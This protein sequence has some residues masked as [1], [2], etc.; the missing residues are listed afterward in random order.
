M[1]FRGL[2]L[3]RGPNIWSRVTA[4]EVT[5]DLDSLA[6]HEGPGGPEL[7]RRLVS[8]LPGLDAELPRLDPDTEAS[9][10]GAYIPG[11]LAEVVLEL[12][13]RAGCAV[14]FRRLAPLPDSRLVRV[15]VQYEAEELARATLVVARSL[16]LSAMSD[17]PFALDREQA[18]LRELAEDVCLGPSTRAIVNAALER[19][20]PIHR[21]NSGSLVQLGHGA[22]QHRIFTAETDQ[23]SAIAECIAQDKDLTRRLLRA[24]GVRVPAGRPVDGPEDA[25]EA[26][27][28]IGAPVV[29]KPRYGNHGRGVAINLTSRQQVEAAYENAR[30]ER[31]GVMVE[32]FISGVEHRLLVVGE[33]LV[34]AARGEPVWVV[35]DGARHV[36]A[37]IDALNQD[38]RRG[39]ALAL[40][41]SRI[42]FDPLTRLLLEQQGYRPD[43]V[44]PAGD[45]VLVRRNGDLTIDATDDVHP[46]VARQAVLAA[47]VVGLNVAGLDIVAT[48]ISRPLEEQGGA[49]VEVNAGPG[50]LMHLLPSKGRPRPVGEAIIETMYPKGSD[51][52]V[53]IIAVTGTNGKT[54]TARIVARGLEA[55]GITVGLACSDGI[56]VQQA[57][58]DTGDCSGPRSARAVLLH[59]HVEAAVLETGRGGL[60]REGLGFDE[61]AVGIV[62]NIGGGDHLGEGGIESPRDLAWVK[63]AVVDA[64]SPRGA[65]VLNA[66]DALAV[67][68]ATRCRGK[69]ILFASA[70]ELAPLV[71][72]RANGGTALFLEEGWITLATN[73]ATE[74]L[75]H[76]DAI[77]LVAP[78]P[79]FMIENILAAVA[80]LWQVGI[81][82]SALR[83]GL[84]SFAGSFEQLPGRWQVRAFKEATVVVDECHNLSAL[85][86]AIEGLERF[87][88]RRRAI[89][90][91][92]RGG[93]DQ[94]L[95][96]QGQLL[97]TYFDRVV[98]FDHGAGCGR[99]A[100]DAAQLLRAGAKSATR[101]QTVSYCPA[102]EDAV[103]TVLST[104]QADELVLIQNDKIDKTRYL[105]ESYGVGRQDAS[106]IGMTP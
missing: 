105:I 65:A 4:I 93:R 80:A 47:R 106:L 84:E 41:L 58:I 10:P 27:V 75:I 99:Q 20:I 60:L 81:D 69:V 46:L 52:R 45:R 62:T 77:S 23:T 22:F 54:I 59:P 82:P 26:A 6:R 33:K 50:L 18:R 79:R 76:L 86:A 103:S 94:D 63:G 7:R 97:G 89:V 19:G 49:I 71:T 30:G 74:R 35:G 101:C 25:W 64:V 48:D 61:C 3:L 90:Y 67:E 5:L 78:V 92:A 31:D 56:F 43:S 72:H 57:T 37:L 13:R 12:Q 11:F 9:G 88:A 87:S 1:D 73:G 29:V 95:L 2:K 14:S 83:S 28:E 96:A 24:V 100:S 51:G 40:P 16:L 98:L 68:L 36:G 66:A 102:F 8:L 17:A 85:L 42:E 32:E 15:I 53:P 70:P 39:E 21:L 34:A 44:P 91:A 104:T 55:A 38:P